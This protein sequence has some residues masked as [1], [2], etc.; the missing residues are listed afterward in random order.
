MLQNCGVLPGKRMMITLPKSDLRQFLNFVLSIVLAKE[1]GADPYFNPLK[2][3]Y[4][5]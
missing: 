5:P 3:N 1:N 2:I 4:G